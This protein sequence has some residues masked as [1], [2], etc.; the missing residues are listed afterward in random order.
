MNVT[1]SVSL[2]PPDLAFDHG[3]VSVPD[4]DEAIAW[5][6]KVLGFSVAR[7]FQLPGSEVLGAILIR[8]SLRME[9][10]QPRDGE[11]LPA[12]RREPDSD[13][14][15]HGNKHTAFRVTDVD[16]AIAWFEA[17]GAEIA[18]RV[19]APF[20]TAVFVRDNAGNLIEFLARSDEATGSVA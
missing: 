14:Q 6:S 20:G 15:V 3:A 8:G 17:K 12:A 10:F 13:L 16:D 19:D 1:D 11:P 5:Y 7:R 2:E 9:L 18:L 4:I